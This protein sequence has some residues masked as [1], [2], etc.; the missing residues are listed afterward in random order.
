[1]SSINSAAI[2]DNVALALARLTLDFDGHELLIMEGAHAVF[3]NLL[4][5]PEVA[6]SVE[7]SC[8]SGLLNL[9]GG[10]KA[11]FSDAVFLVLPSLLNKKKDLATCQL[12]AKAI[13]NLSIL[14][15]SRQEVVDSHCLSCSQIS[16][17]IHT[18][19]TS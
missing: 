12:V 16:C 9:A 11:A 1:M 5:D 7:V 4:M 2:R 8:L 17:N 3:K 13:R 19:R 15:A 6:Y 10:P 18:L 14:P